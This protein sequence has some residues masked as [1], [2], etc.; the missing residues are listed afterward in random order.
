[1][2]LM[3]KSSS[4]DWRLIEFGDMAMHIS[5]RINPVPGDEK[6]YVGLEHL[7]S[8]SLIVKR[9]GSCVPLKGQKLSIKKGDIL[10]AKRNAYLKR[11]ALAPFD[12]IFSAHGMVIR[13]KSTEVLER[14]LPFYM[15]SDHFMSRAKSISEGSLS[16]TIKWKALANQKFLIPPIEIQKKVIAI[17]TKI[18]SLVESLEALYE[19]NI[20]L[21]K[22]L[23]HETFIP[24]SGWVDY[25][26]EDL[27]EVKGGRQLSPE[28][29][30]GIC[31]YKYLRPANIKKGKFRF[32]D[33][34]EMDFLSEELD[35]YRLIRGDILLVEGGEAEDVGDPAIWN[36]DLVDITCFK[37]TLIRLRAKKN[38]IDSKALYW[39][40]VYLHGAGNFKAIAAGTKIKHIG[41]SNTANMRVKLPKDLGVLECSIKAIE[42]ADQEAVIL[43]S[44]IEKA[45]LL[46]EAMLANMLVN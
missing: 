24:K 32:N 5:D 17:M 22:S 11:V 39:L 38:V 13:P 16:P 7:Q 34:K 10:F 37:N 12:G 30:K 27:C 2:K 45:N 31:S 25:L 3:E 33:V 28:K 1:M 29:S 14:F 26:I 21:L 44:K 43:R 41:T 36:D 8:G 15:Q 6:R 46:Y 42:C 19:S 4:R 35:I 18:S 40:A 23:V 9:W 20:K